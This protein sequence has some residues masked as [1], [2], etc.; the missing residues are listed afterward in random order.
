M[1]A[2]T[3]KSRSLGIQEQ[4]TF[5]ILPSAHP[6]RSAVSCWSSVRTC[7]THLTVCHVRAV[8]YKS[9]TSQYILTE[10]QWSDVC[11]GQA[12]RCASTLLCSGRKMSAWGALSKRKLFYSLSLKL[13]PST[14]TRPRPT[15]WAACV[16]SCLHKGSY[17]CSIPHCAAFFFF[18]TQP[19]SLEN[20]SV[21][22]AV[23]RQNHSYIPLG[24]QTVD[25]PAF[26][27]YWTIICSFCWITVKHFESISKLGLAAAH[28]PL[29]V[30]TNPK[31]QRWPRP[32][33][34]FSS[35]SQKKGGLW[36]LVKPRSSENH[37][38]K[39]CQT[40]SQ[41]Q[42]SCHDSD[43][44]PQKS[45]H[46]YKEGEHTFPAAEFPH[47][48]S[49]L[50]LSDDPKPSQDDSVN[51]WMFQKA[52]PKWSCQFLTETRTTAKAAQP[53]LAKIWSLLSRFWV[54]LASCPAGNK[55]SFIHFVISAL[56]VSKLPVSDNFFW[57]VLSKRLI[58]FSF[59]YS[60]FAQWICKVENLWYH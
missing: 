47:S 35:R 29:V 46:E 12:D 7:W 18:Y 11:S 41:P 24:K 21:P 51:T 15:L 19:C 27:E 28:F 55:N 20:A 32:I 45:L 5:L 3:G 14:S 16:G 54:V 37:P 42:N 9:K 36:L 34:Q 22:E 4:S 23:Y 52:C 53:S 60:I 30:V 33:Q 58:K 6:S 56:E 1:Y 17:G 50:H 57:I 38:K 25:S 49:V 31:W 39:Q 43:S 59:I 48:S 40:A 8:Q 13:L 44:S 2:R 10:S 26:Q